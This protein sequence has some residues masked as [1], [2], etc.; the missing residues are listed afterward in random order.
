MWDTWLYSFWLSFSLVLWE[1]LTIF[2]SCPLFPDLLGMEGQLFRNGVLKSTAFVHWMICVLISK[3]SWSYLP[4]CF[5]WSLS[6]YLLITIPLCFPHSI[7][8]VLKSGDPSPSP[9]SFLFQD[10]LVTLKIQ[11]LLLLFLFLQKE[12]YMHSYETVIRKHVHFRRLPR[13]FPSHPYYV[14]LAE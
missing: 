1:V 10:Y 6:I 9:S 5:V 14:S 2:I 12:K 11:S 4:V 7:C 13:F 3:S 8:V